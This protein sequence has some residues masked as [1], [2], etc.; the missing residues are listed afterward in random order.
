MLK[1]RILLARWGLCE[2]PL[3]RWERETYERISREN[4]EAFRFLEGV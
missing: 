1:L 3:E 2:C 4:A